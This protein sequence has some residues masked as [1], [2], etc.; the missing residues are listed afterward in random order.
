MLF[1]SSIRKELA[2]SFGAT[3][4]ALVT[5]V[6][7]M[8]LIRTLG[9]ASKGSVNPSEVLMVMGYTVLGYLAPILTLSLFIAVVSTLSRM[10]RES[11]MVIWFAGGQGL[12]GFLR[13]LLRFAWPML[14]AVAGLALLVWPWTNQQI[15]EMKNRYEKRGDLERVAPGQFQESSNGTRVFFIDK[16]SPDARTGNN[17]FISSVDH[18]KEAVTSAR[19]A[20]IEVEEDG[21]FLMLQNGQRVESSIGKL[22][23]KVSEFDEYGTRIGEKV[24][25]AMAAVPAR[26]RTTL[27]LLISRTRSDLAELA[28]RIGL[29]LASFNFVLIA[30]AVSSGNPRS[31][32]GGNQIL[33]LFTFVVYYNM[34]N[35]GQNWIGNGSIGFAP[36]L[37][38]LHGGVFVLSMVWLTVRHNRWTLQSLTRPKTQAPT[39]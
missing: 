32:R 34:L 37:L 1:H 18:G 15:A 35:L 16:D 2:R 3:L 38:A 5:V 22:D 28:W 26:A 17:V 12:F 39:P 21:R 7:T 20:R 9:Q 27:D 33:A 23:L 19:S 29:A 8:M 4:V 25:D 14:L 11:E 13:P 30:L 36:F 10:Y 24:V 6:M 31:A